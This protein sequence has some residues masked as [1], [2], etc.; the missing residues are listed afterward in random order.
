MPIPLRA[1]VSAG[2]AGIVL[3]GVCSATVSGDPGAIPVRPEGGEDEAGW[4]KEKKLMAINAAAVVG[5]G[6]YGLRYWNYGEDKFHFVRE[7]WFQRNSIHGGADKLG[8]AFSSQVAV[9]AYAALLEGWG[10]DRRRAAVNGALSAWTSFFMMEVG[11]A[12][13]RHGF[14]VEDLTMDS[15]GVVMGYL[16]VRF[17][18][19]EKRVD[20]RVS[21]WPSYGAGKSDVD[22]ASDYS[23]YRYLLAFKG[24]G[25]D[26]TSS[27][28]LRHL[29]LH[30]GYYT[31]G[32]QTLDEDHYGPPHRVVYGAVAVNLSS[33]LDRQD[34][35]RTATVLHYYQVPF[36]FAPAAHRLDP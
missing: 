23:G 19:F 20:F 28:W 22:Y 31:R 33:L 36:V 10:Y 16:R 24:D 4:S 30:A 6:A 29:E 17:P 12:L 21:Y 8:H 2:L 35:H 3:A 25:Y 18:E 13:S 9:V 11:D 26:T 14:S 34:W 27:T 1:I 7:R 15:L 5:I 32:Y